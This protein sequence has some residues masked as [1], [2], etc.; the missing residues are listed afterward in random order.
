MSKKR[1][2]FYLFAVKSHHKGQRRRLSY[3]TDPADAFATL[4]LRGAHIG[5]DRNDSV[6]LGHQREIQEHLEVLA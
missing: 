3:G 1:H 4:K 6:V 2:R 5:V